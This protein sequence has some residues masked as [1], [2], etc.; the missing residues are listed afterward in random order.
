ML[1]SSGSGTKSPVA[2]KETR[3][4]STYVKPATVARPA[5]PRFVNPTV[6][7]LGGVLAGVTAVGA[8]VTI[9]L[10]PAAPRALP[11]MD[12]SLGYHDLIDTRPA[13]SR[14]EASHGWWD[15]VDSRPAVS[16]GARSYGDA[17]VAESH[18]A[19]WRYATGEPS[20]GYAGRV[21]AQPAV[22][23]LAAMPFSQE[24]GDSNMNADRTAG[25]SA[26]TAAAS[27]GSVVLPSMPF[28]IGS[29]D[30]AEEAPRG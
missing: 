5:S 24:F 11:P 12:A 22:R 28:S 30:F 21:D 26:G 7:R 8:A 23:P 3:M 10:A 15:V 1:G 13:V 9:F 6:L 14:S 19:A 4:S 18:P 27:P 29:W 2:E 25:V 17:D 20:L 16:V